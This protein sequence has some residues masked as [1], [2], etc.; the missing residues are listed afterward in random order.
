[1]EDNEDIEQILA[2]VGA[3]ESPAGEASPATTEAVAPTWNGQ[4]WEFESRG[5]KVAPESRETALQWMAKGHDY[6]RVLGEWNQKERTYQQQ[7]QGLQSL[8]K[9][10]PIDEYV[11]KNP[12]WW[13]FV[14]EQWNNRST[15]QI[16]P[17][18]QPALA[19]ILQEL[20]GLKEFVSQSQQEKAAR[21]AQE[22]IQEQERQD[23]LLSEEIEAT[24]KAYPTIDLNAVDESGQ[25]LQNRI[26]LHA[27]EHGIS[28]F[29]AAHRDYLHDKLLDMA[30]SQALEGAAKGTELKAK[31]GLLGTTSAP[32]KQ[33][34][35]ATNVRGKSYDALVQEALSELGN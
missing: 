18:L 29:R 8:S 1:M 34:G 32:T 24:R 10:Q 6:T 13:K 15:H 7:L 28:S 9:F 30:R 20:N 22:A 17:A 33:V 3:E 5:K 25:T 19:P 12:D 31:K 27:H 23:A 26:I 16:D 35:K 21:E 11:Q 4:E 14:E 2:E